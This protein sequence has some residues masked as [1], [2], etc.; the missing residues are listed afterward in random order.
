MPTLYVSCSFFRSIKPKGDR[1]ARPANM[2]IVSLRA[3]LLGVL[4]RSMMQLILFPPL[5][6]GA[7]LRT[8]LQT[9]IFSSFKADIMK[10]A[11]HFVVDGLCWDEYRA[12]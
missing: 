9:K 8:L 10:N 5:K 11:T 7:A 6:S 4:I 2:T 3:L 12:L 1:F